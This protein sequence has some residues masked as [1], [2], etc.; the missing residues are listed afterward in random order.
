[1]NDELSPHLEEK[2]GLKLCI[3]E[4]DFSAGLP[5][6]ENIVL[7]LEQSRS[8]LVILSEG[9]AKSEWCNFEL[10]CA[11]QMF[12]EQNRSIV[13]IVLDEPSPEKLKKTMKYILKTRTY[14]EWKHGKSMD[15]LNSIFWERLLQ[16]INNTTTNNT[17]YTCKT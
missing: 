2:I 8:C 6:I 14:L 1:M 3:H 7:S 11:Y 10:N 12:S 5:I 15:H 4:R 13:V 17:I 9:Y 16:T